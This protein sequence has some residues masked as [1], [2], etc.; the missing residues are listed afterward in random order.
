MGALLPYLRMFTDKYVLWVYTT[1]EVAL[2]MTPANGLFPGVQISPSV[3]TYNV[4]Y[5][6]Q[7][8]IAHWPDPFIQ[9]HAE[10]ISTALKLIAIALHRHCQW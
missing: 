1:P 4:R 10:D 8:N 9:S 7:Q 3:D 6:L 5:P 2:T